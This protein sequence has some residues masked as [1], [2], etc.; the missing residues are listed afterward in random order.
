M[1]IDRKGGHLSRMYIY[2]GILN[3]EEYGPENNRKFGRA[4]VLHNFPYA[5]IAVSALIRFRSNFE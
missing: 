1:G 3:D 2:R 5:F 4:N